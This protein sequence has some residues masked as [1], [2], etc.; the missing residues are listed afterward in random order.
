MVR[1]AAIGLLM[2][3]QN[4]AEQLIR[5]NL[6]EIQ[7]GRRAK[8]V[9][10]GA[11]SDA[12]L[13]ALNTFREATGRPPMVREIVFIGKHLYQSRI[14][15]DGYTF[16]DVIDQIVS[17]MDESSVLRTNRH[18]TALENPNL[19]ADRY[20]NNVRDQAVL[21]CTSRHP[22]PE[23]YSV[24]PIGDKNKPRTRGGRPGDEA[25]NNKGREAATLKPD[26]LARV[27]N[28]SPAPEPVV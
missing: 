4:D 7:A 12:Q 21:E 1:G 28:F 25:K 23:L 6:Q 3:L 19:R 26:K 10:V 5:R 11:L 22:R 18:M 14:E 9:V 2:P 17:A 16:D 27:K 24:I 20:G 15:R 13:A 8:M